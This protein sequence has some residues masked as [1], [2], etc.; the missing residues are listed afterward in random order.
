LHHH[1]RRFQ[2]FGR[3]TDQYD[4]SLFGGVFL[5]PPCFQLCWSFSWTKKAPSNKVFSCVFLDVPSLK[6]PGMSRA[7]LVNL[8]DWACFVEINEVMQVQSTPSIYQSTS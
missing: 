7:L 3:I 1:C 8:N 6:P 4:P 5:F 2:Y